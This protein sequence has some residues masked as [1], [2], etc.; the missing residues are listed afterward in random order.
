MKLVVLSFFG[1][2]LYKDA[3]TLSSFGAGGGTTDGDVPVGSGGIPTG[4]DHVISN[5]KFNSA[6]DE[7]FLQ[8]ALP[9]GICTA[10]PLEVV[11]YFG[12][13]PADSVAA[14]TT[15]PTFTVSLLA[16]GGKQY[17]SV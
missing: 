3:I 15:T 11:I 12:M 6:T 17:F 5:S 10:Y 14:I 16:R 9:R 1:N 2:A 7:V 8:S 4:W 13:N